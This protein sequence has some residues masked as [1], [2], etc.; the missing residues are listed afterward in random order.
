MNQIPIPETTFHIG[1]WRDDLREAAGLLRARAEQATRGPWRS[2]LWEVRTVNPDSPA[3]LGEW[4]ADTCYAG[5]DRNTAAIRSQANGTWVASMHPLVGHDLAS[6]FGYVADTCDGLDVNDAALG[7]LIRRLVRLAR[8]Y[9]GH[10][11]TTIANHRPGD[12][13]S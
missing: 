12:L 3:A 1:A 2:T 7:P 10:D 6:L 5:V 11:A 9:L 8:V 4:V 13:D